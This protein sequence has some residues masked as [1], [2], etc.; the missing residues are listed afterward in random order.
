[1]N[2]I[3][4]LLQKDYSV[5]NYA[6]GYS[7][8]SGAA[9]LV[10]LNAE[11]NALITIMTTIKSEVEDRLDTKKTDLLADRSYRLSTTYG[12]TGAPSPSGN[13]SDWAVYKF[14]DTGIEINESLLGDY[15]L[16]DGNLTSF[17]VT[18]AGPQFPDEGYVS[19]I[20]VIDIV[21][22]QF[23]VNCGTNGWRSFYATNTWYTP[24][25]DFTRTYVGGDVLP[26]FIGN[27]HWPIYVLD[28]VYSMTSNW[29]ND[30]YIT[31]RVGEYEFTYDQLHHT[32]LD[33]SVYGVQPKIDAITN[34][35]S[36][37]V[38]NKTKAFDAP[39]TYLRFTNWTPAL[40]GSDMSY[41]S[42]YT[43]R[44]IGD[45]SSILPSG[46][47][48]LIDCG[49]DG[50]K[51]GMV[52]NCTYVPTSAGDYTLVYLAPEWDG[53]NNGGIAFELYYDVYKIVE[54]TDPDVEGSTLLDNTDPMYGDVVYENGYAFTC[55]GDQTLVFPVDK[56]I[57]CYHI[58]GEIYDY[59]VSESINTTNSEYNYTDITFQDGM[60]ITSNITTVLIQA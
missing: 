20:P 6:F 14:V 27:P 41:L 8:D 34:A 11:K 30:T 38:L 7:I 23:I 55:V 12:N 21:D 43:F 36:F 58:N 2:K 15:F 39:T 3:D 35:Q 9:Q 45:T 48:V 50:Y 16:S 33:G 53:V 28:S 19:P 4:S 59:Y 22:S 17:V 13:V 18:G 10:A 51:G 40:S 44:C 24:G 47:D 5:S 25:G 49:V 46:A 56:Y 1:M 52:N 42:D 32:L 57:R 54:L 31:Q 29:D 60:P 26:T 37:G